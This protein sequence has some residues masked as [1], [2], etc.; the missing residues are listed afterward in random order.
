MS[1]VL[2]MGLAIAVA[3]L[4]VAGGVWLVYATGALRVIDWRGLLARLPLPI[5]SVA[6]RALSAWMA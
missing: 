2:L 6:T 1:N 4:A 5:T 3:V